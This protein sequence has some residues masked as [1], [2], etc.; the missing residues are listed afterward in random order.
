LI[1]FITIALII[2]ILRAE[3]KLLDCYQCQRNSQC[4]N[5]K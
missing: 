3:I 2:L 1:F 4:Q 5:W